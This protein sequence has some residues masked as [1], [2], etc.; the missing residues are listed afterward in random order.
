MP[1]GHRDE[2]CKKKGLTPIGTPID[3]HLLGFFVKAGELRS[4]DWNNLTDGEFHF[5]EELHGHGFA[6]NE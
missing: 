1:D 4:S 5:S 3:R 2:Q 6:C